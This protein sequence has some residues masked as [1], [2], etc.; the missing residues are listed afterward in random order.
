MGSLCWKARVVKGALGQKRVS[1][2]FFSSSREHRT[3]D[4]AVLLPSRI[5][6][7]RI[8]ESLQFPRA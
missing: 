1:R 3:S 8:S 6:A 7:F 5:Q 4:L 2:G